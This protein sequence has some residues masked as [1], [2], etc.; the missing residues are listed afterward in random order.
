[1]FLRYRRKEIREAITH[2]QVCKE[3]VEEVEALMEKHFRLIIF[4][5][6]RSELLEFSDHFHELHF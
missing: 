3:A 4:K 2:G 5:S 6:Y 1:M